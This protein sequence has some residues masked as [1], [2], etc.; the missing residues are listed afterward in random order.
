MTKAREYLQLFLIADTRA[1]AA[2]E[3]RSFIQTDPVGSRKRSARLKQQERL[4]L[5]ERADFTADYLQTLHLGNAVSSGSSDLTRIGSSITHAHDDESLYDPVRRIWTIHS[6]SEPPIGTASAQAPSVSS[7]TVEQSRLDAASQRDSLP[8]RSNDVTLTYFDHFISEAGFVR[9]YRLEPEL[10]LAI[11]KSVETEDCFKTMDSCLYR[12]TWWTLKACTIAEILE[13]S[14]AAT[15]AGLTR[16]V[17]WP[18]EI[19]LH[20]AVVDLMKADYILYELAYARMRDGGEEVT[21]AQATLMQDLSESI[22]AGARRTSQN[23]EAADASTLLQC[24]TSMAEPFVQPVEDKKAMPGAVDGLDPTVRFLQI[25]KDSAGA[26]HEIVLFRTFVNASVGE[27]E[28]CRKSKTAPYMLVLWTRKYR[29]NFKVSLF[30]QHGTISLNQTLNREDIGKNGD[31]RDRSEYLNCLTFYFPGGKATIQF[32]NEKDYDRFVSIPR[33]FFETVGGIYARPN[34]FMVVREGLRSS[35]GPVFTKQRTTN[36]AGSSRVSRPREITL[37]NDIPKTWFE[38]TRRLVIC[39]TPNSD[40]I[41]AF[42]QPICQSIW[43]PL[44]QIRTSIA[45]T[46]V[47]LEWANFDHLEQNS[48]GD[49]HDRWSYLHKPEEPNQ[50]LELDFEN[51]EGAH[52]FCRAVLNPFETGLDLDQKLESITTIKSHDDKT[53]YRITR[54]E[55][56]ANEERQGYYAITCTDKTADRCKSSKS[57]FMYAHND[58]EI[59]EKGDQVTFH[60]LQIPE[61]ISN[62]HG[63]PYDPR[64]RSNEVPVFDRVKRIAADAHFQFIDQAGLREFF[65]GITDDWYLAFNEKVKSVIPG[66]GKRL[67]TGNAPANVQV[68]EQCRPGIRPYERKPCKITARI[69]R[70]QDAHWYTAVVDSRRDL[71]WQNKPTRVVVKS[72]T[73]IIE[74]PVLQVRHLDACNTKMEKLTIKQT[75][76]TIDFKDGDDTRRFMDAVERCLGVHRDDRHDIP[77]PEQRPALVSHLSRR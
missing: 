59:P 16:S 35:L 25:D 62:V 77:L 52:R 30:N 36:E 60:S 8:S 44:S 48:Q 50:L 27:R 51:A 23:V 17:S 47:R 31:N 41:G 4:R 75:S 24:R 38:M 20:Q 32:L 66:H 9:H 13:D 6:G 55:D 69:S 43:L 71:E 37:Y 39:T 57:Y 67:R 5:A 45:G 53:S 65:N 34:E 42:A 63:L 10:E 70:K 49:C 29:S 40:M 19:S 11:T 22:R 1:S 76:L 64:P 26:A 72:A 3:F 33:N 21:M 46:Q 73:S 56:P 18:I 15:S 14:R 74:G 68:W 28:Y 12:A 58:L 2:Q 54:L 7:E 61:Y